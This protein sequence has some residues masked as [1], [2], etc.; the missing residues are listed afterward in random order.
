MSTSSIDMR[1]IHKV[2]LFGDKMTNSND[3]DDPDST[4]KKSN[5]KPET[6]TS[7]TPT[8]LYTPRKRIRWPRQPVPKS[9]YDCHR[10]KPKPNTPQRD[11]SPVRH[12]SPRPPTPE[13]NQPELEIGKNGHEYS[14]QDLDDLAHLR[15]MLT[16]LLSGPQSTQDR[17]GT[18]SPL[19]VHA[20]PTDYDNEDVDGEDIV[21]DIVPMMPTLETLVVVIGDEDVWTKDYDVSVPRSPTPVYV[22]VLVYSGER[23]RTSEE[24]SESEMEI[25]WDDSSDEG[26][27]ADDEM[28]EVSSDISEFSDEPDSDDSVETDVEFC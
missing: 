7:R 14:Q 23:S 20:S 2:T 28:S 10:R 4:V 19:F 17:K 18:I 26:E 13:N 25:W 16:E 11:R 21:W 27:D 6:S 8:G 24:E 12:P 9:K 15:D 22:P 1:Q 5:Q 3:H